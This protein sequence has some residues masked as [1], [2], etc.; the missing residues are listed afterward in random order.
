MQE[1]PLIAA[2]TWAGHHALPLYFTG[3]AL[4]MGLGALLART[5]LPWARPLLQPEPALPRQAL[6]VRQML[7]L[8][9]AGFV[10]I[11][12]AAG[13]FAEI[14]ERI[15]P[16]GRLARLDEALSLAIA[17]HTPRAWLR[18]F[19]LLT[20]LADV[21]T[22]SL[23][24]VLVAALLWRARQRLLALSWTLALGGNALL[25]P[26]LKRVFERVRPVHEHGL[27]SEG[28]W[29]FP[30][31]H[32]SGAM[33]A[34]GMLAYLA[35][36]LLPPRWHLPALLAALA[37]VFS[38]GFS[39]VLLQ[40]HFASDVLAGW[41]SGLAWLLLSLLSVEWGRRAWRLRSGGWRASRRR[42]RSGPG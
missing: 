22:L 24:G 10:L 27:V 20:H 28:G 3:L 37:T 23:L 34:Y 39:R 9:A 16:N 33:V 42:S 41:A 2:A 11:V 29:S 26:A 21:L 32:S 12:S 36:R 30:S 18:G 14:A 15:A 7:L 25:N 17:Q 1:D 13:L 6:P 8:S 5:L 4:L 31:G 40:V 19:S 35:L 38:V